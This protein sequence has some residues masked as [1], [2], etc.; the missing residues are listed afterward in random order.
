MVP[1]ITRAKVLIEAGTKESLSNAIDLLEAIRRMADPRHFT[2][3][4]IDITVLQ[5]LALEKQGH[6]GDA[7]ETLREAVDLA[8]PGGWVRPFIE[9]GPTMAGRLESL[10]ERSDGVD[11]IRRALAA[12]SSRAPG[13]AAPVASPKTNL[14]SPST[15]E[16]ASLLSRHQA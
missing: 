14:F 6:T 11:F 8:A 10:V 3:Q 13:P 4:R 5:S 16:M 15:T 12:F 9:A 7:V 2:N 1:A